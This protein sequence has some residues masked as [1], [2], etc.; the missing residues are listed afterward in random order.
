M[1]TNLDKSITLEINESQDLLLDLATTI[2]CKV[3]YRPIS[4]LGLPLGWNHIVVPF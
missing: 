4:Y 1:K 2:K 3:F